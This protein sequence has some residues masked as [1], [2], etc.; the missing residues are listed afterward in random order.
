MHGHLNVRLVLKRL[1]VGD[2]FVIY[3]KM[4]SGLQ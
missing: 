1:D 4:L 2:M 3:N